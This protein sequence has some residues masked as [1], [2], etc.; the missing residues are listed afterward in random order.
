MEK[1]KLTILVIDDSPADVEIVRRLLEQIDSWEIHFLA[2]HDGQKGRAEAVK[3]KADLILLD[4]TL[5]SET[6][7][8]VLHAI[9]EDGCFLPVI[10]LTGHGSEEIA[11]EAMKAG[12][13]DYLVKG[14]I[15]SE[16]LRLVISNALQKFKMQQEI[17]EQR[18][19]LLDAERQRVMMESVGA[20][21]H[22]FAQPLT[23]MLGSLEVLAEAD[24]IEESE[25]R[26]MLQQCLKAA[27]MMRMILN[28][29]QQVREYRTRPYLPDTKILDIGL[30]SIYGTPGISDNEKRHKPGPANQ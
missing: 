8:E 7:L 19:A 24:D 22:H 15:T 20:A 9:Q 18:K 1:R 12:V 28:K 30:G 5:G 11:V 2:F 16:S 14:R 10:M 21:C 23:T 13:S 4:Y 6:G 26:N 3:G 25:K 27:E 17:E 29:F